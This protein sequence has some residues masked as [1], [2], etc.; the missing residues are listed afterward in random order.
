MNPGEDPLNGLLGSARN[1]GSRAH[2][3]MPRMTVPQSPQQ[4]T[5]LAEPLLHGQRGDVDDGPLP[6]IEPPLL[7][8][9]VRAPSTRAARQRQLRLLVSGLLMAFA[10]LI[11]T[12]AVFLPWLTAAAG[13]FSL[14]VNGLDDRLRWDFS[15]WPGLGAGIALLILGA[16]AATIR[17]TAWAFIIGLIAALVAGGFAIYILSR[18]ASTAGE[19]ARSGPPGFSLRLD[20]GVGLWLALFG[21]GL[22]LIA[23]IAGLVAGAE[24]A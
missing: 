4:L 16:L 18:Q 24:R 1:L 10:G 17:R 22:G 12:G 5:R 19:L 6:P 8:H 9:Q 21:A 15:G 3:P 20:V 2:V 13:R 14:S 11:V 23:A 7:T